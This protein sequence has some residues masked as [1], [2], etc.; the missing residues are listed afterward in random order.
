[1]DNDLSAS[2]SELSKRV[3]ALAGETST[4]MPEFNPYKGTQTVTLQRLAPV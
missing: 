2:A 4:I 3:V 1:M